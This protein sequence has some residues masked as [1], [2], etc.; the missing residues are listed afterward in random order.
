MKI[1]LFILNLL[2][3]FSAGASAQFTLGFIGGYN[4][5]LGFD[6][7]WN[8]HSEN[9][10]FNNDINKGI[11]LGV[12]LRLGNM[13]FFQP[14][15]LYQLSIYDYSI[16]QNTDTVSLISSG[17]ES[18]FDFPILIG[19]KLI[20]RNGFN[21]RVMTGPR[22]RLD[23]GSAKNLTNY[24]DI[25][26]TIRKS[27][28]GLDVGVGFDIQNFM[29]DLRYNLINSINKYSTLDGSSLNTSPMN[30]FS[31]SVGMKLLDL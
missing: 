15:A 12:M 5:S 7:N 8:F 4:T 10:N 21:M 27:Q 18:T 20:D 17:N 22:F 23:A 9:I 6:E 25:V 31:L 16:Q 11:H 24:E 28:V 30:S 2:L 1:R 19:Y 29:I 14:E 26:S 3:L 13:L